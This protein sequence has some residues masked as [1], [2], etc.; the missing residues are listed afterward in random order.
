MRLFDRSSPCRD[1]SRSQVENVTNHKHVRCTLFAAQG[2]GETS[3][4]QE[5]DR[6]SDSTEGF[7]EQKHA[8]SHE[9]IS[10]GRLA[11]SQ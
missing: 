7:D 5:S 3:R 1:P 2:K 6:K 4:N 9:I 10:S 8:G 11:S